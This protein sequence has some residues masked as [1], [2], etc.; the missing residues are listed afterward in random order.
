MSATHKLKKYNFYKRD[1]KEFESSRSPNENKIN[2]NVAHK[3][4]IS[5]MTLEYQFHKQKM[6]MKEI[7]KEM[8]DCK[9]I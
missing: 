8:K 4:E 2:Y 6:E 5:K 1:F 3:D 7:D 9:F